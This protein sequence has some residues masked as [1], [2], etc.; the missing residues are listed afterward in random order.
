VETTIQINFNF[1]IKKP[2]GL[3]L[4][5][6]A[7]RIQGKLAEVIKLIVHNVGADKVSNHSCQENCAQ[8]HTFA[9]QTFADHYGPKHPS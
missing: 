6:F 5:L 9:P 8:K 2:Q 3:Y 1:D 7:K 4:R